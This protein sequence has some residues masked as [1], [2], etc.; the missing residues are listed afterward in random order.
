MQRSPSIPSLE[1]VPLTWIG[2][3]LAVL[4]LGVAVWVY[5]RW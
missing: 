5:L 3:V 1:D 2:A 4:C